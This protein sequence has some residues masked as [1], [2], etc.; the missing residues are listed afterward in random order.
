MLLIAKEHLMGKQYAVLTEEHMRFIA[1][2]KIFFVGTATEASR[3]NIS[4]KGMNSLRVLETNR[5][6]WLNTTGSGNETSAH[7]QLN[8]RMTVMFCAFDGDPVILRL[9]GTAQVLHRADPE[10]DAVF[11]RFKPLPGTRQVFDLSID[12]VQTSCGMAVPT[13]DYTGERELLNDWARTKGQ[14]GIRQYWEKKNQN[15]IDGLPT[16]IL[17]KSG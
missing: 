16:N 9:Y 7:V 17:E 3:V 15:S 5:V 4:P 12:L 11:A 2:Q 10:W 14:D 1:A 13:F 8:P 6:A